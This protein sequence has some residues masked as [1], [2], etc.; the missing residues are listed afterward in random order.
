MDRQMTSNE[1]EFVSIPHLG[2][3]AVLASAFA[4][5]L[6]ACTSDQ[7]PGDPAM[8]AATDK[9]TANTSST[10]NATT[11]TAT[12]ITSSA[13]KATTDTGSTTGITDTVTAETVDAIDF[14]GSAVT[15]SV[16]STG[17][18]LLE[19]FKVEHEVQDGVCH[20]TLVRTKADFC[21]RAPFLMEVEV[22]WEPPAECAR[23][24]VEFANPILDR[25]KNTI[26]ESSG[27]QLPEQ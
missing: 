8:K 4:L 18:T 9:A 19:H 27:R 24:S 10:A 14:N 11:D 15:A 25:D 1:H 20:V 21:R 13:A 17:C 5:L 12:A 3:R 16:I 26:K 22:P 7:E 23:M 6:C 2:R